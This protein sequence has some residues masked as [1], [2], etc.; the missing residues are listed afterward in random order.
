MCFLLF[1]NILYSQYI[2]LMSLIFKNCFFPH[3][4]LKIYFCQII[5]NKKA[6]IKIKIKLKLLK[7]TFN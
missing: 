7:W 6:L 1:L 2:F 3:M 5:E 4:S